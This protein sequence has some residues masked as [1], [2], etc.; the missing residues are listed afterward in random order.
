MFGY[1]LY[2][3]IEMVYYISK[4]TYKGVKN[5]YNWYYNIDTQQY[6]N[7]IQMIEMKETLILLNNNINK[8]QEKIEFQNKIITEYVENN[9]LI[10]NN[11]N[12]LRL[13]YEN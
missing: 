2:E 8:M 1:I 12:H 10:N 5:T 3:T 11:N 9:K 13:T 6:N 4:M 7:T